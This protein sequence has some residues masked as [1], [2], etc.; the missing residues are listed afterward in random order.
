MERVF[1]NRD[2]ILAKS[3]IENKGADEMAK[4]VQL[5]AA[6]ISRAVGFVLCIVGAALD[7]IFLDNGL[8][9]LVCWTVYWG[10]LATEGWVLVA[11]GKTKYGWIGAVCNTALFLLFAVAFALRLINCV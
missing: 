7:G 10:M 1:M 3:R 9:G 5:K 11:G 4:Q 8:I 2:E 6:S